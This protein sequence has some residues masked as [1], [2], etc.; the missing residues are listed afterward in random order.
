MG[1][2]R[3]ASGFGAATPERGDALV[4]VRSRRREPPGEGIAGGWRRGPSFT[5][6]PRPEAIVGA[7]I[8]LCGETP[9]ASP[10]G[11]GA[12]APRSSPPHGVGIGRRASGFG[13]ATLVRED[14]L[15]TVRSRRHGPRGTTGKPKRSARRRGRG[16]R[17]GAPGKVLARWARSTRIGASAVDIVRVRTAHPTV[18]RSPGYARRVGMAH[19]GRGTLPDVRT[20]LRL[21]GRHAL[22]LR[23]QRSHPPS[24]WAVPA[25]PNRYACVSPHQR[26]RP[27]AA[28][29]SV[30]PQGKTRGAPRQVARGFT[31]RT[32]SSAPLCV[33]RVLCV[34]R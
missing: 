17:G 28:R 8:P 20:P 18:W 29:L 26:R 21:R 6:D 22:T 24:A 13:A 12:P 9:V 27:E 31:L 19:A 4:T 33:L 14:A 25:A 5:G 15:V 2:A 34:E 3:T 11:S 32:R 16:G 10:E 7:A 30:D 23:S 1:I